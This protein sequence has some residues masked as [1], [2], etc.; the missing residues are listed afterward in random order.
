MLAGMP[1]DVTPLPVGAAPIGGMSLVPPSDDV[2]GEGSH[3][4]TDNDDCDDDDDHIRRRRI[5]PRR[6]ELSSGPARLWQSARA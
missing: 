6:A 4:G 1:R 2:G 5:A 3:V